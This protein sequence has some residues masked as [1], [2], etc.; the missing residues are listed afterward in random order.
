MLT[1]HSQAVSFKVLCLQILGKNF[2]A[3]I[4]GVTPISSTVLFHMAL[5]RNLGSEPETPLQGVG[6]C[7]RRGAGLPTLCLQQG[8]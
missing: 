6:Q 7:S 3:F 5:N 8:L 4:N 1:F 2:M